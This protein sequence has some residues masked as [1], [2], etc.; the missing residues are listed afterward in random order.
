MLGCPTPGCIPV[1]TILNFSAPLH[2]RRFPLA[3]NL[4]LQVDMITP[5][6]EAVF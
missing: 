6:E 3:L 2:R 1:R 4:I 5:L